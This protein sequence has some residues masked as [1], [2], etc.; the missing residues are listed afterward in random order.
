MKGVP[1]KIKGYEDGYA[2][3]VRGGGMIDSR[4]EASVDSELAALGYFSRQIHGIR[5]NP[6]HQ[7]FEPIATLESPALLLVCRLDAL[8]AA[9]VRRMITDSIAAEKKGLWAGLILTGHIIP[10]PDLELATPGWWMLANNCAKSVCLWFMTILL[11]SF[12][13]DTQ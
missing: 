13:T 3:D 9:I 4:D 12:R 10:R 2:G 7:R 1:L 11:R 8:T 6:Y 5:S